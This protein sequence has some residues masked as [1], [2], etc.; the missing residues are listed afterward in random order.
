VNPD[1]VREFI[2]LLAFEEDDWIEFRAIDPT[3]ER[4]P[5]RAWFKPSQLADALDW[6]AVREASRFNVYVGI[7]PRLR[8]GGSTED[9]KC[10]RTLPVDIDRVKPDGRKHERPATADELG[11]ARLAADAVWKLLKNSG[12]ESPVIFTGNGFLLLVPLPDY[13]KSWGNDLSAFLAA[14]NARAHSASDGKAEVDLSTVDPPR[15]IGI[16]GTRNWKY[17]DEPRERRFVRTHELDRSE[18]I[19]DVVS[20]WV[21][22]EAREFTQ[23]AVDTIPRVPQMGPNGLPAGRVE[24]DSARGTV[25]PSDL[26]VVLRPCF[27]ESAR[28]GAH[29]FVFNFYLA[30]EIAWNG[31]DSLTIDEARPLIHRAMKAIEPKYDPKTT[32]YYIGWT[33]LKSNTDTCIS[34]RK[35]KESGMCIGSSCTWQTPTPKPAPEP[36]REVLAEAD[37]GRGTTAYLTTLGVEL[38]RVFPKGIVQREFPYAWRGFKV[39]RKYWSR[40]MWLYDAVID[41]KEVCGLS[42]REMKS[43]LIEHHYHGLRGRDSLTHMLGGVLEGAP[44]ETES[45]SEVLGFSTEGWQF[46]GE[47]IFDRREDTMKMAVRRVAEVVMIPVHED[48]ARAGFRML[49]D[50]VGLPKEEKDIVFAWALAAPFMHAA[51]SFTKIMPM[52]VLHGSEDAGKTALAELI[53]KRIWGVSDGVYSQDAVGTQSRLEGV[54]ASSTFPVAIDDCQD[55]PR[56]FTTAIL[57]PHLTGFTRFRRKRGQRLEVDAPLTAPIILNFNRLPE[58]FMDKAARDRIL[59]IE[60]R[61]ERKC[62]DWAGTVG[63][64][65]HGSVGRW[66]IEL[67]RS[68]TV[69][70]LKEIIKVPGAER[71]E[72]AVSVLKLGQ[73]LGRKLGV[74]LNIES[75]VEAISKSKEI[76]TDDLF[77]MVC[78]MAIRGLERDGF[79]EFKPRD[80]VRQPTVVKNDGGEW[81]ILINTARKQELVRQFEGAIGA[82]RMPLS[83]LRDWLAVKWPGVKCKVYKIPE[84]GSARAV[85][86][87]TRYIW[88]INADPRPVMHGAA[89]GTGAAAAGDEIELG[90]DWVD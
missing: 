72:R 48:A 61:V 87:P 63:R 44:D 46:P 17:P 52:L 21:E 36:D 65:P 49:Y 41:E 24:M 10:Y 50:A 53:V 28:N 51:K 16:P 1:D 7:N 69:K 78:H 55:L 84:F 42:F 77:D 39:I 2:D 18:G 25:L 73:Y 89:G 62:D 90:G 3:R 43:Y 22:A 79:G 71:F 80:W 13:D 66:I 64:V 47:R 54:L 86:V 45:L 56:N 29:G 19:L 74:R 20:I 26:N 34:C 59:L 27:W 12:V 70:E 8:K 38:V 35:L 58:L 76:G 32:D 37:L 85:F 88:G 11:A 82:K 60:M 33:F 57:K 67:T 5:E 9:V 31:G 4:R 23:N 30:R 6:I 40:E 75:A 81:G 15:V 83:E 68:W 14:L